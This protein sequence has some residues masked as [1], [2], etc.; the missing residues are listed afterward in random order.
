MALGAGYFV[1]RLGALDQV[2]AFHTLAQSWVAQHFVAVEKL[3]FVWFREGSSNKFF[4]ELLATIALRAKDA[5]ALVLHLHPD[6]VD[7]ACSAQF[8]AIST[9]K[10]SSLLCLG[11]LAVAGAA[12]RWGSH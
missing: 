11:H 3:C 1:V 12:I 4:F 10:R 9:A 5:Q 7:E 8:V 6:E 2:G